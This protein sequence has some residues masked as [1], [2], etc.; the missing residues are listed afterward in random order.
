M[1]GAAIFQLVWRQA[2]GRTSGFN[3]QQGQAIFL[4]STESTQAVGPTEPPIQYVLGAFPWGLKTLGSEADLSPRSTI[5]V[6][7]S[8][9]ILPLLSTI[10]WRGD[11]MLFLWGTNWISFPFCSGDVI[12]FLWGTNWISFSFCSG[13]IMWSL[14]GTNWISLS[15]CS[16]DTMWSL[17]GTNWISLSFC[18]VKTSIIVIVLRASDLVKYF[19][20]V[21]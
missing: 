10:S 12:W 1:P 5:E 2:L 9:A 8:G 13:D 17:W 20:W 19:V 4:F 14:W 15:F 11:V 7:H 18:S 6:K 3:S 16:G 21:F